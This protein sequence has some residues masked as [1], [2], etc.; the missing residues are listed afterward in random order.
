MKGAEFLVIGPSA[1]TSGQLKFLLQ[2]DN[3]EKFLYLL[4]AIK[5]IFLYFSLLS[6]LELKFILWLPLVAAKAPNPLR[7]FNQNLDNLEMVQER[8]RKTKL[9]LAAPKPFN[10]DLS[11]GK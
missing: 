10:R 11:I 1:V 5:N 2:V 7:E 6:G 9:R 4:K 8:L 3:R